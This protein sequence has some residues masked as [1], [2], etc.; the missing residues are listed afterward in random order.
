MCLITTM[1][2]YAFRGNN[3]GGVFCRFYH[4]LSITYIHHFHTGVKPVNRKLWT[5]I[6]L[7]IRRGHNFCLELW[8]LHYVI[9]GPECKN[10]VHMVPLP[11]GKCG[12]VPPLSYVTW[13]TTISSEFLVKLDIRLQP[14]S[15]SGSLSTILTYVEL[16]I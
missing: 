5:N 2:T 16:L 9:G 12:H 15:S 14:V 11:L 4:S 10:W 8:F 1:A 3:D 6:V 7:G 13:Q